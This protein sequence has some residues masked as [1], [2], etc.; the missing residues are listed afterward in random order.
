MHFATGP[1]T[2]R[3]NLRMAAYMGQPQ[4][5][6]FEANDAILEMEERGR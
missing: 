4:F 6:Q 1:R 5:Q 3:E 2:Y